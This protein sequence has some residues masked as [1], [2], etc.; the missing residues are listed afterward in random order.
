MINRTGLSAAQVKEIY[1]RL[2]QFQFSISLLEKQQKNN[3]MDP[4]LAVYFK[5]KP[6]ELPA[7]LVE[8]KA[9]EKKLLDQLGHEHIQFKKEAK[10]LH[11]DTL[12]T[13]VADYQEK[14]NRTIETIEKKMNAILLSV[15]K[16]L[17]VDPDDN[18]A[19]LF[20]IFKYDFMPH[21]HI[22]F[23]EEDTSD[24]EDVS[25]DNAEIRLLSNDLKAVDDDL[26]AVD[27]EWKSM[28]DEWEAM[29][30]EE[31]DL[32]ADEKVLDAAIKQ[33]FKEE[34]VDLLA[35]YKTFLTIRRAVFPSATEGL[36]YLVNPDNFYYPPTKQIELVNQFLSKKI[37]NIIL[38]D[39]EEGK[40]FLETVVGIIGANSITSK[41]VHA[42]QF[43]KKVFS[44]PAKSKSK[45]STWSDEVSGPLSDYKK[46]LDETIDELIKEAKALNSAKGLK[47]W[48]LLDI[49]VVMLD[50]FSIEML[51]GIT[52]KSFEEHHSDNRDLF[53]KYVT[54]RKLFAA[55]NSSDRDEFENILDQDREQSKISPYSL[56]HKRSR[57]NPLQPRGEALVNDLRE[58][59]SW[60]PRVGQDGP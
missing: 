18:T 29:D 6:E 49:S 44:S 47:K 11:L 41:V 15:Y 14:I 57:Y 24:D 31:D 60:Y 58:I 36:H 9:E 53:E 23:S 4:T 7:L 40:K 34:T 2:F 43:F 39:E 30:D 32:T 35:Q 52:R 56:V 46:Y 45:A 27:D 1:G 16:E 12:Y 26:N 21:S 59:L 38:T 25:D 8:Y 17:Q 22:S 3:Q 42:Q 10:K 33:K 20:E 50:G 48:P 28:D 19:M 55:L 5:K 51:E 37:K 13:K 54:V